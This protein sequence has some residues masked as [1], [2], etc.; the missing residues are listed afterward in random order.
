MVSQSPSASLA[1]FVMRNFRCFPFRACWREL[2]RC[3]EL[4][5]A[6]VMLRSSPSS[7]CQRLRVVKVLERYDWM[8]WDMRSALCGGR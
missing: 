1:M 2:K 8:R 4:W 7:C 3:L 6:N 5:K